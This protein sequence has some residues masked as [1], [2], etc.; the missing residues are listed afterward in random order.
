MI[1]FKF[2]D[3]WAPIGMCGNPPQK[4]LSEVESYLE[5]YWGFPSLLCWRRI[6][7]QKF[8]KVNVSMTRNQEEDGNK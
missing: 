5:K 6:W 8:F 7:H 3:C 2:P 4:S 1:G